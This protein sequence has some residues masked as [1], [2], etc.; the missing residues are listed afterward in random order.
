MSSHWRRFVSWN[1]STMIER[2][3]Q[4]SRSRI[5]ALSRRRSR[6][7]RWRSSKSSAESRALAAREGVARRAEGLER[8]GAHP[9]RAGG[10]VGREQPRPLRI[11]V[12]A[13][14]RQRLLEGL[15]L[16]DA[17]LALVQHAVA[18]IDSRRERMRLQE[19]MAEA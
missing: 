3:R 12:R 17:R 5:S 16:D 14:G 11:L 10:A 6:A 18:R 19:A 7:Y 4:R 15:A 13:E 8:A 2:R 1:S 9:G